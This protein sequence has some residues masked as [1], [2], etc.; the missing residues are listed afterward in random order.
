[1]VNDNGDVVYS[2]PSNIELPDLKTYFDYVNSINQFSIIYYNLTKRCNFHC[3]YCYSIHNNSTVS[4]KNNFV[5]LEKINLLHAKSL[6]LIGGEPFCHPNFHDILESIIDSNNFKEICVVTNGSLINKSKIELYQNKRVA[7]QISID[8]INEIS[9]SPTRGYNHFQIVFD[10]IMTLVN[11]GVN[12]SVMKVITRDNIDQSMEFYDFYRKLGI[13][14]GFFMVKQVH[15]N[16]KP[17]IS[18]LKNLLDYVYLYEGKDLNRVF[19]IVNFADNMMFDNTGFPIMHCGAGINALSILPNG[20][21]YPCVKQERDTPITNLLKE[22]A[23]HDI[24]INRNRIIKN[25]LVNKKSSC[26]YCDLQ[27]SC[28]GG[29]RAEEVGGKV[30]SYNCDYFHFAKKYYFSKLLE[31]FD[32]ITEAKGNG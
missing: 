4:L 10:N 30:C 16:Q 8:G 31:K 13:D 23:I 2:S 26:L 19:R 3:S 11:N 20:N 9:N 14:V 12:V 24:E 18:Q 21:V 15:K 6:V 17:T 29:C 22:T 7:I 25:D 32:G 1:M 27:Y 5:F 28:G